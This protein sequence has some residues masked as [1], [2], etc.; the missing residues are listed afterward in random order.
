[1]RASAGAGAAAG[2]RAPAPPRS[3][4]SRPSEALH[5]AE[6]DRLDQRLV[7]N[8]PLVEPLVRDPPV[9]D[10]LEALALVPR[11]LEVDLA[12]GNDPRL[13]HLDD[14]AR[15]S[16]LIL[17]DEAVAVGRRRILAVEPRGRRLLAGEQRLDAPA[18]EVGARIPGPD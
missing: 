16:V 3:C 2:T 17:D 13:G 14:R 6:P 18:A 15:P 4:R 11:E 8:R 5:H 12:R 10:R 7:G 1:R 9:L